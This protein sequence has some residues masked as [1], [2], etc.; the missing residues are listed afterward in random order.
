MP[1]SHTSSPQPHA[2]S[3]RLTPRRCASN[4]PLPVCATA[5]APSPFKN[6]SLASSSAVGATPAVRISTGLGLNGDVD[7]EDDAAGFADASPPTTPPASLD[8][9]GGGLGIFHTSLPQTSPSIVLTLPAAALLP[10]SLPP[11]PSGSAG[12]SAEG[13]RN[14]RDKCVRP[15]WRHSSD[16]SCRIAA[17]SASLKDPF[18]MSSLKLPRPLAPRPRLRRRCW[19]PRRC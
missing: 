16:H 13:F 10:L 8:D 4:L 15:A 3:T 6:A 17:R 9:D 12:L 2:R 18:H 19:E 5:P 7:V 14:A 11:P 1:A